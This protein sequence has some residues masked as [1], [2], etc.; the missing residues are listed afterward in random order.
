MRGHNQR[1]TPHAGPAQQPGHAGLGRSAVEE[2]GRA[3]GVLDQR[4]VS[5]ADVEKANGEL[6]R[7]AGRAERR[8]GAYRR[9]RDEGAGEG[10]PPP[11]RK[12]APARGG[13]EGVRRERTRRTA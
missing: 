2:D 1:E 8:A 4:G 10:E 11:A 13:R 12:V 7:R 3:V 5:L 9:E 6:V